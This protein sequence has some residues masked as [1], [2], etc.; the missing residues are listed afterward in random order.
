MELIKTLVFLLYF[1]FE[2]IFGKGPQ[3]ENKTPFIKRVLA[4]KWMRL[5]LIAIIMSS[6]IVNYVLMQKTYQLAKQQVALNKKLTEL[7]QR[8]IL[9]PDP[10]AQPP[11]CAPAPQPPNRPTQSQKTKPKT[12]H[13]QRPL[14]AD[15]VNRALQ[16]LAKPIPIQP[17]GSK[18]WS[19]EW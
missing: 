16:E 11:T 6:L 4:T 17:E 12:S 13:Q 19:N 7:S 15:E 9:P 3:E 1:F 2:S 14:T 18:S 10:P 5:V 8:P